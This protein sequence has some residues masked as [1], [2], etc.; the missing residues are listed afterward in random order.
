MQQF[1]QWSTITPEAA[2]ARLPQLLAE[3]ETALSALERRAASLGDGIV[4]ALADL[5]RPVVETWKCVEHLCGVANT[6]AWREIENRFQGDI[7]A[8]SLRVGQSRPLYDATVA[9]LAAAA[10]GSLRAR[11]LA[12]MKLEAELAGVALEGERRECFNRLQ[13]ELAEIGSDFANAVLDATAAF[14]LE[15]DGK[16]Y[17]IDDA[18]YPETMKNCPDRSVREALYRARSTRAPENA[19]RIGEIL[20]RRRETAELLGFA[21]YA[22]LSLADKCAPGV[23]S[24]FAMI[25]ELDAATAEAARRE[26]AELGENLAPWDFAYAAERLR[27]KRYAYSEDE[28]KRHLPFE[29]VLAGLF[30]LAN[31]LFGIEVAEISGAARP[32]VWHPDVRFFAVREDGRDIAHFYLDPFVRNGSKRGGAWMD[33]LHDRC[34]RLGRLPLALMVLNLPEPDADGVCL[35]PYREV[36]TLFHEFGHA[37]QAMLTRIGDEEC[38]GINMV[39]WDAVEVASQFME[40]WCFD[41]RTG[42]SVPAALRDK[43]LAARNFRAASGCRRQLAFAETDLLLHGPVTPADP[44]AV[45]HERFLHYGL[46]MVEN[47]GFLNAFTHIFAG[48]YAAGY[49]GYKWSEVMSADCYGAFEEASLDC[50]DA[51][52]AAGARYRETVLGLGGSLSA[53][54]V[55]KRFRGR[56]PRIDALLRQQG[57]SG[58]SAR[59]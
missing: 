18:N 37:L 30:R 28:L 11:V 4:E 53:Y 46:P 25:R 35:M 5:E 3:A 33:S 43:V 40:N 13:R 55:F 31:R 16:R 34:D 59:S 27:E 45:K 54:E 17:T 38:A 19:A 23:D 22:A 41:E 2:A 14:S 58:G 24:V 42:L 1:P 29:S 9:A 48:G 20:K 50:D 21:D 39:E 56:E 36:E 52:R 51:V 32:E 7:V 44:N 47:D 57:L 15:R 26:D 8:L 6:P 10:P 49:Y 12:R